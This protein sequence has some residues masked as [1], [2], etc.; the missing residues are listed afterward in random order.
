MAG[1]VSV[2]PDGVRL[3]DAIVNLPVVFRRQRRRSLR[4]IGLIVAAYVAVAGFFRTAVP[5]SELR[6]A[7]EIP[8]GILAIA[9]CLM[10]MVARSVAVLGE[11]ERREAN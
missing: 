4:G 6:V 1:N 2:M 8:I 10:F 5:A 7:P 3:R 11:A 9:A